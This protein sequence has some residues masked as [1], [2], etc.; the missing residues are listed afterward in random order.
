[1][2][3]DTDVTPTYHAA[4]LARG[5]AHAKST[6]AARRA[7]RCQ[8]HR[9]LWTDEVLDA[10]L[11]TL[12]AGS[13]RKLLLTA[14]LV[15]APAVM[16]FDEPTNEIDAASVVVLLELMADAARERV[17]LITTHHAADLA[18]LPPTVLS[19]G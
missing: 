8:H 12:S 14:A 7:C 11:G 3:V 13:A 4:R 5:G 6:F 10:P 9:A 1:M 18:A 17:V 15:A 2:A 19:L 16:L